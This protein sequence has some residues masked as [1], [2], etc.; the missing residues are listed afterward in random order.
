MQTTT[1]NKQFIF[2]NNKN[3]QGATLLSHSSLEPAHGLAVQPSLKG[4][5]L[6]FRNNQVVYSSK[7][8]LP[9]AT[10]F[11]TPIKKPIIL[12]P[13]IPQTSAIKL[14]TPIKKPI[15]LPAKKIFST[16]LSYTANNEMTYPL[17]QLYPNNRSG[18]GADPFDNNEMTYPLH[19]LYPNNSSGQGTDPFDNNEMTYPLH[20]LYPN[21]RSGLG[22]DPFLWLF[23]DPEPLLDQYVP[24]LLQLYS[25]EKDQKIM[26]F[27]NNDEK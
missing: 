11:Y 26:K 4:L 19:Q 9:S 20:Q 14:Y 17:H 8:I 13:I 21:N 25:E 7:R 24:Y 10:K 3:V 5:A 27:F 23:P 12:P 18:L 1:S 6:E 22:A 2:G 16:S 15:I